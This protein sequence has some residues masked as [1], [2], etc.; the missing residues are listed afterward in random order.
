MPLIRPFDSKLASP[1][2]VRGCCLTWRR[3]CSVEMLLRKSSAVS[4]G[5]K[6]DYG[7]LIV[8]VHFIDCLGIIA[9]FSSIGGAP[10]YMLLR[11]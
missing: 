9:F 5:K 4:Y 2:S 3:W 10:S 6:M 7:G 1:F 11:M 8:T